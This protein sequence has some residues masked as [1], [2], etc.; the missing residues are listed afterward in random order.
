[1]RTI[2]MTAALATA[3]GCSLL[4][5][6]H[7]RD[8]VSGY[9]ARDEPRCSE[10]KGWAVLDG[11]FAG[12]GLM[13]VVLGAADDTLPDG[14]KTAYIIGGALDMIVHGASAMT[15]AGW[16]NDCQ[17]AYRIWNEEPAG[18]S[19]YDEEARAAFAKQHSTNQRNDPQLASEFW[20]GSEGCTTEEVS[21]AGQC[22]PRRAAWCARGEDGFYVCAPT[23]DWCTRTTQKDR[24]EFSDCLERFPGQ[25][26]GVRVESRL[27]RRA[28]KPKPA[29]PR[30]HFCAASSSDP[31]AG[32]CARMKEDCVRARDAAVVAVGDLGECALVERAWCFVDPAKGERCTP[33]VEACT[34][35]QTRAMAVAAPAVV[36]ECAEVE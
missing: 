22:Q 13:S 27:P 14:D 33:T 3:S 28:E 30:G 10:S 7:L 25:P 31:R 34:G 35:V 5:Q 2:L 9:D 23:R 36:P 20:C 6:D 32:L 12:M 18:Q 8:G 24:R 29:P 21:C 15:G 11:I 19:G 4:F 1:M 26:G 17:Q 16:A